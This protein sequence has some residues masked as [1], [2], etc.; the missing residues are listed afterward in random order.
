MVAAISCPRP[1]GQE[2]LHVLRQ[3][4]DLE[5]HG[6]SGRQATQRRDL[7]GVR[8]ETYLEPVAGRARPRSA[9]RRPRRSSP[10]RPGSA[11]GVRRARSRAPREKPSAR[12]D[13]DR[14]DA[15][16]VALHDVAAE[17][18]AGA[19][20]GLEVHAVAGARRRPSVLRSSVSCMASNARAPGVDVDRRQA[21]AVDRD[22]VARR[23][24]RPRDPVRRAT[25]ASSHRRRD[26][27]RRRL[28]SSW[29]MPVNMCSGQGG[30][31]TQASRRISAPIRSALQP[32]GAERVRDRRRAASAGPNRPGASASPRMRGATNS[33]TRSISA[34]A[35]QRAGERRAALAQHR[36]A[37]RARRARAARRRGSRRPASRRRAASS[38]ARRSAGA[39]G[40]TSTQHRAVRRRSRT[41]CEAS[42][43]PRARG[44]RRPAAAGARPAGSTS[45]A[46]SAGSSAS[47]VPIP[48][49]TAPA[50]A[51]HS[52]TSAR[53]SGDGDPARVAGRASPCGRPASPPPCT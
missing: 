20:R 12:S 22:G 35:Q 8:N 44:R 29:T 17:R 10:S 4:V 42:G 28:P 3:D 23:R 48:T 37:R 52:C 36:L 49:S 14:A 24:R 38:A 50:P 51:R 31:R 25:G 43:E 5:V 53:L 16:D 7:A 9:T 19:Q 32:A 1:V 34:A 47:A 27:R 45:R 6:A 13:G 2:P 40:A 39:S 18:L 41:S 33:A 21:D 46:V 11:E 30:S 26:R 15:V